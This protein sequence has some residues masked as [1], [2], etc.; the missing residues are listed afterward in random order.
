MAYTAEVDDG[1]FVNNYIGCRHPQYDKQRDCN[2]DYMPNVPLAFGRFNGNG[3]F[4]NT[5]GT[6]RGNGGG[7][8]FICGS[9]G[10]QAK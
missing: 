10:H 4:G 5:N 7:T 2:I 8:C 1:V 6:G 9:T 3:S